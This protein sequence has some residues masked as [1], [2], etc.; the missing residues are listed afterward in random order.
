MNLHPGLVLTWVMGALV[1]SV[2]AESS[3]LTVP[4][5]TEIELTSLI[6]QSFEETGTVTVQPRFS[7]DA[8]LPEYC[9]LS[10]SVTLDG[11]RTNLSPGTM[12]CVGEDRVPLEGKVEGEISELG[13]CEAEGAQGC[14]LYTIDTGDVGQLNLSSDL[15]LRPQPR[16]VQ[17]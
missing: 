17:N 9:L 16:S 10:V 13:S 7:G 15:V 4:A 5:A 2:M 14:T 1:G 3:A 6:E 8:S 12:I 11:G